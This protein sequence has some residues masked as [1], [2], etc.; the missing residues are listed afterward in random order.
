L[1]TTE[2]SIIGVLVVG[3][4][5]SKK[6]WKLFRESLRE[7]GYVEGQSTR[8]E[9]RSDEGDPVGLPNWR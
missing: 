4:S 1:R 7:L 2:I 3:S 9:F 5:G 8:F 6:F